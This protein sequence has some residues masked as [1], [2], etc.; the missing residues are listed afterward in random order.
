LRQQ[1]AAVPKFLPY[2]R[3]LF[4]ATGCMRTRQVTLWR[5]IAANLYDEYAVGAEITWW[6]VSSCTADESVA[7]NFMSQLGGKATLITLQ[8]TSAIDITPLS[9]YENEKESL[10]MPGTR[11]KVLS[12]AW[13]KKNKNVCEIHVQEIA[14][15][16]EGG[17][18]REVGVSADPP[19]SKKAKVAAATLEAVEAKAPAPATQSSKQQS[20]KGKKGKEA[21]A[22]ATGVASASCGKP[23][24]LSSGDDLGPLAD[25]GETEAQGSGSNVYKIQRKGNVYTC[26][27]PAWKNQKG[28]SGDMRTCKHIKALRGEAAEAARL[29]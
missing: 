21:L 4:E 3:L 29:G 12:R 10:L 25:G 14:S 11:F 27:C 8:T 22:A 24:V 18:E 9:I 1:H 26:S 20:G 19:P 13:S 28:A 23:G 7:R 5:G 15:A 2:L 17:D 6:S 16:L